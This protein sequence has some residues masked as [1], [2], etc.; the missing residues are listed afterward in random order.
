MQVRDK[1]IVAGMDFQKY[2]YEGPDDHPDDSGGGGSAPV[3]LN[4]LGAKKA[5]F[6]LDNEIVC[7][8]AGINSTMNSP[9]KTTVEHRRI[10]DAEGDDQYMSGELLP[11]CEFRKTY[12]GGWFNMP[13]H[14]GYVFYG[15]SEV[16]VERYV[17]EPA[18]NQSFIK[19][20]LLHGTN[21][22]NA[23]YAYAILPGA[24]NERVEALANAPDFQIIKNI[25]QLQA[26]NCPSLGMKMFVFHGETDHGGIWAKN[27]C[28]VTLEDDKLTI[29]DPTQEQEE[30]IIQ[31]WQPL[32]I[33]KKPDN[34]EIDIAK[35]AT[36]IT[37][38]TKGAYGRP[39]VIEFERN[40][41]DAYY[42]DSYFKKDEAEFVKMS[43]DGL[44]AAYI[45]C[46]KVLKDGKGYKYNDA[47]DGE[48]A[49]AKNGVMMIPVSFFEKFLG[50]A[51]PNI[52]RY[53]SCGR[54]YIPALEGARALGL[55][56]KTYYNDRLL[57]IGSEEQLCRI[58]SSPALEEAGAYAVFGKYDATK[59]TTEDY[60]KARAQWRL[61]LVGSPEINDLNN[62][63]IRSK[64]AYRDDQ[65]DKALAEYNENEDRKIL[66]GE[67]NAEGI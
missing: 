40:N 41:T 65:C 29:C 11:K 56:A 47:D 50:M 53:V 15:D 18:N 44:V 2:N 21:P 54:E 38:D 25:P 64:I 3:H 43:E 45:Y 19:V 4:D 46:N 24:D 1:Y 55:N 34:V 60:E 14:A 13:G 30:L 61:R 66:F 7:L 28:I 12:T 20:N 62:E 26:I 27:P 9:V 6:M 31:V 17:H 57:V 63:V 67:D 48:R 22:E 52:E 49:V 59:F 58:D 32:V 37:V 39:F 51:A 33:T 36:K 35:G 42:N 10:V 23:S 16:D 8:G 5:W